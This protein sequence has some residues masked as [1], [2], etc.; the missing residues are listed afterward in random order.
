MHRNSCKNGHESDRNGQIRIIHHVYDFRSSWLSRPFADLAL[1]QH[2]IGVYAF[3]MEHVLHFVVC[4]FYNH[5]LHQRP[6]SCWFVRCFPIPRIS[7][8]NMSASNQTNFF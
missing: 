2:M 3:L 4:L 7:G 6:L 8:S 1:T 5:L